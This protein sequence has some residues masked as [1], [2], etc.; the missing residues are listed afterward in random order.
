MTLDDVMSFIN[1]ADESDLESI[2]AE[3]TDRGVDFHC[4]ECENHECECDCDEDGSDHE[5]NEF[6]HYLIN[7]ANQFGLQ[8]LLDELKYEGDRVGAFL[9]IKGGVL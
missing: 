6:I 9:N 3:L 4:S 1:E 7:R 2:A 8:D 5:K